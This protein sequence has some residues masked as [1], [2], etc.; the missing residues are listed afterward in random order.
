[1]LLGILN[2]YTKL[3]KEDLVPH[4]RILEHFIPTDHFNIQIDIL[5]PLE[6]TQSIWHR[7]EILFT[8][9]PGFN[10]GCHITYDVS[11]EWRVL[12][13]ENPPAFGRFVFPIADVIDIPDDLLNRVFLRGRDYEIIPLWLFKLED[14]DRIACFV[15]TT[16]KD[17]LV[18][19]E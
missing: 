15:V 13:N 12:C 1:M 7:L 16:E 11:I 18:V 17:T 19:D 9:K 14:R 5:K 8:F 6:P 4:L 10:F 3:M 2:L